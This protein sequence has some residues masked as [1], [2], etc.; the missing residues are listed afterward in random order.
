MS[1]RKLLLLTTDSNVRIFSS[2]IVASL[3]LSL[4]S[5]FSA[6]SERFL[7]PLGAKSGVG[8][9]PEMRRTRALCTVRFRAARA[10][11]LLRA[12][13]QTLF[14]RFFGKAAEKALI[15]RH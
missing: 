9:T 10:A 8:V 14:L 1:E 5:S 11:F 3:H 6:L 15:R 13:A 4:K 12:S 7:R 2:P